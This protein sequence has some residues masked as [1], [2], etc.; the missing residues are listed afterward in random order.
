MLLVRAGGSELATDSVSLFWRSQERRGK[1]AKA[2]I[3]REGE[4]E[5]DNKTADLRDEKNMKGSERET[6]SGRVREPP[7]GP[8]GQLSSPVNQRS[9]S[10][11]CQ[12]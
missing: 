1:E 11:R 7:L 9:R 5:R 8:G 2:Q 6:K 3:E 12:H 4:R 10:G